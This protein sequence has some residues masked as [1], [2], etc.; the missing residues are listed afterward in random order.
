M[1]FLI[2]IR[3]ISI[4][5]IAIA[6]PLYNSRDGETA[7]LPI[8]PNREV[9]ESVDMVLHVPLA[10]DF[11]YNYLIARHEKLKDK[12]AVNCIALYIDLRLYDQACSNPDE[13]EDSKLT[14]A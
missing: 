10:V 5:M 7:M 14:K 4:A 2:F 3:Q 9:I 1:F 13:S 8:L 6:W 12:Q 11:F